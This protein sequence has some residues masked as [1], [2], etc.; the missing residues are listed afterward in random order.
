[1]QIDWGQA[2]ERKRVNLGKYY[3]P[4]IQG[5]GQPLNRPDPEPKSCHM[6]AHTK[7]AR[8]AGGRSV[9]NV[10]T[11]PYVRHNEAGTQ[12]KK[13]ASRACSAS[14]HQINSY[15]Q[16]ATGVQ[17]GAGKEWIH[18]NGFGSV[19]VRGHCCVRLYEQQI[20][21]G[22]AAHPLYVATQTDSPSQL[23]MDGSQAA[24]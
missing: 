14:W 12:A 13:K 5:W 21:L 20:W 9:E 17:K 11:R 18:Q 3:S 2:E 8:L 1:M 23:T 22:G 4:T 7:W 15:A 10:A 6:P 19:S 24:A 16:T